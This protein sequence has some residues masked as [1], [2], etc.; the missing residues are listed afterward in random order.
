MYDNE[1]VSVRVRNGG[2]ETYDTDVT[3]SVDGTSCANRT[4]TLLPYETAKV[5][6]PDIDLSAAGEHILAISVETDD[7]ARAENNSVTRIIN[8]EKELDSYLMDFEGCPDFAGNGARLNPRWTTE[9]RNGI[10]TDYFWRYNHDNREEPCGF[11]A[12]NVHATIPSMDDEPL[13]GFYPHSGD[14]MGVAFTYMQWAPEAAGL[15]QSDVWMVSPEL[16]LGDGSS[17]ELYVKTYALESPSSQPE[18]FR[19]LVSDNGDSYDSFRILGADTRLAAVDEWELVT[20][21]LSEYDNRNVRVAVQY[22]GDPAVNCCLMIDDLH[23]KTNHS[24]VEGVTGQ[25]GLRLSYDPSSQHLDFSGES[26]GKVFEIFSASGMNVMSGSA[27]PSVDV[28]HLS[29]GVY[30]VRCGNSMLK[31]TK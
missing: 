9:D 29:P 17:F 15:T 11:M 23:V 28:S 18:P 3:L 2:Y 8:S 6:F 20:A 13:D 10:R 7:D 30:M 5:D 1:T 14:R 26:A 21:D 4:V 16:K 24:G 12:Y 31:F 25:E 27:S 19:L 22:I